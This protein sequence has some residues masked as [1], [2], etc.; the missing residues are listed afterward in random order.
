MYVINSHTCDGVQVSKWEIL[1]LFQGD[2]GLLQG[3]FLMA[4]KMR[5]FA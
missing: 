5:R 2:W 4:S 3:D 1:I